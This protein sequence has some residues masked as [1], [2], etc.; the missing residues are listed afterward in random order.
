MA[1]RLLQQGSEFDDQG[2]ISLALQHGHGHV[3]P[4]RRRLVSYMRWAVRWRH[5]AVVCIVG[6]LVVIETQTVMPLRPLRSWFV[7]RHGLWQPQVP[8]GICNATKIGLGEWPY[9][10]GK[11][12]ASGSSVKDVRSLRVTETQ[13]RL[14]LACTDQIISTGD[15]CESIQQGARDDGSS[16]E[17]TVDV[18]ITFVE[19]TP[20]WA[21]WKGHMRATSSKGT[22]AANFR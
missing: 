4:V 13:S 15:V 3:R 14:S 16:Y 17:G 22:R 6:L 5:M 2:T 20:H 9:A 18:A 10:S 11:P 12:R 21:R 8:S 7:W 1:S 19:E